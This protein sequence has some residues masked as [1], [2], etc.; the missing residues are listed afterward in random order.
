MNKIIVDGKEYDV[1]EERSTGQSVTDQGREILF[2]DPVGNK[3]YLLMSSM[4]VSASAVLSTKL[5]T[6]KN[7]ICELT[8]GQVAS[9]KNGNFEAERK[10]LTL[11]E[12][13][14]EVKI[15]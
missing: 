8:E 2:R 7:T 14:K 6:G 15:S 9:W 12:V 3:S 11:R 5:L 4:V 13:V 10:K 1:V